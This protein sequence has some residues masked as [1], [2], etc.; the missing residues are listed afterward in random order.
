MTEKNH[1]RRGFIVGGAG[2][3]AAVGIGSLMQAATAGEAGGEARKS[4]PSE[5]Q[6]M[7][8]PTSL[9]PQAVSKYAVST[10]DLKWNRDKEFRSVLTEVIPLL[11][12]HGVRLVRGWISAI[13]QYRKVVGVWE[14]ASHGDFLTAFADPKLAAYRDRL[15]ALGSATMDFATLLVE[16]PRKISPDARRGG[17]I[18]TGTVTIQ[19]GQAAQFAKIL[20][21]SLPTM[22]GHGVIL[23][24]SYH[25]QIGNRN[26][27][28]DVWWAPSA[29]SVYSALSDPLLDAPAEVLDYS[30]A[31]AGELVE[32]STELHFGQ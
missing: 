5:R 13:G 2:A 19:P 3:I 24:A 9:A 17:V 1:T 20:V 21:D 8:E 27:V 6:S 14:A 16:G 10:L 23:E 4:A 26:R 7:M 18:C 15:E 22:A 11:R 25:T 32:I 29:N 28:L 30:T 31:M 12:E